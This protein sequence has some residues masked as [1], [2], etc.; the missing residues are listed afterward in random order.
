MT[1]EIVTALICILGALL[2]IFIALLQI[3]QELRYLWDEGIHECIGM[4]IHEE[5]V[6]KIIKLVIDELKRQSIT[7]REDK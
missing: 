4:E 7:I 3:R 5:D 1:S 2:A 6:E